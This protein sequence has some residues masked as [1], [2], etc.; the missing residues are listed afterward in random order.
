MPDY[1][2][3]DAVYHAIS[4]DGGLNAYEKAYCLD[5]VKKIPAADVARV[6][7]GRWVAQDET[8]TKF[9]CSVCKS[10]NYGGH[11]KFCPVCGVKMDRGD[12]ND[13]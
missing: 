4:V 2:D 3:R 9:M 6:R 12:K 10:K 8:R 11:E 7:H 5:I 13:E 1:I